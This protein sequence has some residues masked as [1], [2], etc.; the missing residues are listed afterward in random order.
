MAAA[1]RWSGGGGD[2]DFQRRRRQ[3][4]SAAVATMIFDGGACISH[5]RGGKTSGGSSC[6]LRAPI[7]VWSVHTAS[8]R[9]EEHCG[10]FVCAIFPTVREIWTIYWTNEH[11]A[12][13]MAVSGDSQLRWTVVTSLAWPRGVAQSL[14]WLHLYKGFSSLFVFELSLFFSLLHNFW[15]FSLLPRR[16]QCEIWVFILSTFG[17]SKRSGPAWTAL[18]G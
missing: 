5:A 8:S 13:S 10:G 2:D 11:K 9:R 4:F 6:F 15:F 16:K 18:A 14:W 17:P 12:Q 7:V 1:K 3:W